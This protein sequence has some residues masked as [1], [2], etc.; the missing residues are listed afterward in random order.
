MLPRFRDRLRADDGFSMIELLVVVMI[1]GLLSAIAIAILTN[2]RSKAEDV[3]A[4]TAVATAARAL[5]VCANDND[6]R[7]NKS[8][9]P[10]DLAQ[11][12]G[13]EPSLK[14]LRP[15]FDDL[16]LGSDTYTVT[17]HSARAPDEVTFTIRRFS[18]GATE[19]VC[20]IGSRDKGGCRSPGGPDNDW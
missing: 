10:C 2:Q 13:I 15:R 7:Y 9:S 12:E 11:L 5:E 17:V 8:G 3:E 19:R 4:K 14:D 18:N 1:I 16:V 20:A 6:G